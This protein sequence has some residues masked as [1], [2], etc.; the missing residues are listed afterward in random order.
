MRVSRFTTSSAAVLGSA[1]LVGLAAV[2]CASGSSAAAS[3]PT[4]AAPAATTSAG[5]A[6]A[7]KLLTAADLP[8]GWTKDPSATNPVM[9]TGC[10]LLNPTMWI[11]M[12][13]QHGEADLS[14]GLAGPSLV[15]QA[16]GGDGG[17][18]DRAWQALVAALPACSTY[19]HA[20][21]SGGSTFTITR[22]ASFPA[23]GDSS[24]A[25]TLGIA[26]TGG[27]NGSGSIV[28][29]RKGNAIAVVYL[30]G[31]AA[32]SPELVTQVV[33]KAVSKL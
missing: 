15:E 20:G 11:S 27:V 28:A 13:P 25:F 2:G 16:A 5:A 17:Q 22:A 19:T 10:P 6:F 4:R 12:L 8:S 24:Y 3:R 14:A 9:D 33:T 23:F 7:A 32:P 18:T 26:I 1:A 31:V 21:S 29:T 30:A